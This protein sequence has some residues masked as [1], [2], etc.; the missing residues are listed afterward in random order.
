MLNLMLQSAPACKLTNINLFLIFYVIP[1][2]AF[3]NGQKV[4][5]KP[6]WLSILLQTIVDIVALGYTDQ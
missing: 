4:F 2:K 1:L 6:W 5:W 3:V